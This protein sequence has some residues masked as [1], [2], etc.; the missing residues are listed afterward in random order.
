MPR[1]A[2]IEHESDCPP[3]W[4][5]TWMAD[6]GAEVAV[7]RPYLG[8]ELGDLSDADGVVILGGEMGANDEDRVP[9]L[10]PLK[11]L[12]RDL[13]RRA[14][15]TLGICLGH[16]L[17]ASALGG[18]VAPDPGGQTIGLVRSDGR[19]TRPP[20]RSS[21][22]LPTRT[23]G[24]L[25]P[26]RGPRSCRPTPLCSRPRP[27][28]CPRPIRFGEQMWGVQFHPEVDA[29]VLR[30]WVEDGQRDRDLLLSR[31]EETRAA[32]PELTRT[33]RPVVRAFLARAE[34]EP[35]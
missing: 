17:I 2:F 29:A 1:I 20:T 31:I 7:V 26:R 11:D 3:A 34:G 8:E 32:E 24:L 13:H 23:V 14:V 28:T 6:A 25:E 15:P 19:R 5:G 22:L 16:Q 35:G 10:A 30:L 18:K 12:V 27:G 33:W 21:A 4:A 9:W